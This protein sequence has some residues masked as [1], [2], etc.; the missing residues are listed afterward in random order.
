MGTNNPAA[1]GY[2]AYS[3]DIHINPYPKGICGYDA[4]QR[5]YDQAALDY[6][7]KQKQNHILKFKP[8]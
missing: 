6:V 3:Q 7:E 1:D 8:K 5:G 2:K 4:W